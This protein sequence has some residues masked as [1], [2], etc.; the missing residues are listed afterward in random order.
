MFSGVDSCVGNLAEKTLLIVRE[1]F[2]EIKGI[3]EI[4]AIRELKHSKG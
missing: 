1:A 2:K 4:K 3:K